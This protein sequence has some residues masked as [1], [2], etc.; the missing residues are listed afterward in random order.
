MPDPTSDSMPTVPD[1]SRPLRVHVVG[2]GGVGMSAI[3]T[4]L[5]GMGHRVTGS[6][7]KPSPVTERLRQLH[8][9]RRLPRGAAPDVALQRLDVHTQH[10]R[11]DAAGPVEKE[12]LQ[13]GGGPDRIL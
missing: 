12:Y 9:D 4:A 2:I 6:D 13:A 8:D 1:I 5:V 3:A 11:A 7:L 10:E